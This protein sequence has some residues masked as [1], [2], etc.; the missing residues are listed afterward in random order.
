MK[1]LLCSIVVLVAALG[2]TSISRA[3]APAPAAAAPTLNGLQRIAFIDV[4]R[5][6][7]RSAAGVAAREVLERDKAGMQK[8]MDT[9]RQELDK[10]REELEKKGPLLTP[11]VRRDKQELFER[12]RRDAARLADD[13]Q[14]ELEKKESTLLQKVLQE[15]SGIIER[16]GKE[17]GYYLIVEKRGAGVIY[18][19]AEADL[20]DEVIREYD[21]QSGPK[22][23]ASA[24]A[25]TPAPPAAVAPKKP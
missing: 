3:Q 18:A 23:A 1:R 17:K 13:F 8:E 12:K 25:P 14:K 5:V 10:L 20:T 24:P 4:Q 22:P 11:D 6:L 21:R 7:A 16:V 2:G 19:A 9:K 15:V